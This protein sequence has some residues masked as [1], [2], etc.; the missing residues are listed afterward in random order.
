LAINVCCGASS[1]ATNWDT[2]L[3]TSMTEPPAAPELVLLAT[4]TGV[5][6]VD[7]GFAACGVIALLALV[8]TSYLVSPEKA[9]GADLAVRALPI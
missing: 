2:R 4:L 6:V 1:A 9:A 5:V 3:L 8:M 7:T